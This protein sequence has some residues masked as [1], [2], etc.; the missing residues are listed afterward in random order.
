MSIPISTLMCARGPAIALHVVPGAKDSTPD[1]LG[2]PVVT[3]PVVP[4]HPAYEFPTDG[5]GHLQGYVPPT[6]ANPPDSANSI[7]PNSQALK[8]GHPL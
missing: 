1:A 4:V 6:R 2:Y 5:F 7:P 3:P 8:I